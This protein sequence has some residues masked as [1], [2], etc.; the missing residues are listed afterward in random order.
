MS[1]FNSTSLEPRT[2]LSNDANSPV[3]KS[4]GVQPVARD[5]NLNPVDIADTKEER[6]QKSKGLQMTVKGV[7]D[8]LV[9]L[10]ISLVNQLAWDVDGFYVPHSLADKPVISAPSTK[11]GQGFGGQE[12]IDPDDLKSL[13]IR[14]YYSCNSSHWE[15]HGESMAFTYCC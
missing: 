10:V 3:F 15:I 1:S 9:P 8:L 2:I 6:N 4:K 5:K 14:T 13:V 7:Q 12:I 11:W